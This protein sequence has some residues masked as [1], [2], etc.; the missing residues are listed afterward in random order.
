M[1]AEIIPLRREKV[2][3]DTSLYISNF[4][5][6][7]HAEAITDLIRSRVLYLHSVVFEELLAGAR[8]RDLR[9]LERFK[10]PFLG[11]GRVVTPRDEDWEETGMVVNRLIARREMNSKGAVGLTHDILIALSARRQGIRVITENRRDFELIR[12]LKD[13]KLTVWPV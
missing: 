2:L 13:F 11:A 8:S 3:L 5:R 1:P 4:N 10:K 9:Q 12:S 7:R 6:N